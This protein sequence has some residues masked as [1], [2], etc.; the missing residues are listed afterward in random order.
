MCPLTAF[1]CSPS[2]HGLPFGR[3]RKSKEGAHA[4][5]MLIKFRNQ[6][7]AS[8]SFVSH[9]VRV[10]SQADRSSPRPRSPPPPTQDDYEERRVRHEAAHFLSG[11]LCGLP[12]KSYKADGGTTLVEFY[13]SVEGD[14]AGRALKFTPDEVDQVG[15]W[16]FPFVGACCI[17]LYVCLCLV[18]VCLSVCFVGLSS[19]MSQLGAMLWCV[20]RSSLFRFLPRHVCLLPPFE[21]PTSCLSE[22]QPQ[23]VGF[24]VIGTT[25][26]LFQENIS[27]AS[28]CNGGRQV[29]VRRP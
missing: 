5:P 9:V 11:Y 1:W 28:Y 4:A 7:K 6:T 15:F 14:I 20:G 25:A 29:E 23:L 17:C 8:R 21:R 16:F 18:A 26:Y 19:S 10:L 13:D 3:P 2:L 27:F 22:L 24:V 12:I